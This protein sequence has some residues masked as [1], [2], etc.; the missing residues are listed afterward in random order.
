MALT[1]RREYMHVFECR[2]YGWKV[3][4]DLVHHRTRML[5]VFETKPR[6]A[7]GVSQLGHAGPVVVKAPT[8]IHHTRFDSIP[9]VRTFDQCL[10]PVNLEFYSIAGGCF[11]PLEVRMFRVLRSVTLLEVLLRPGDLNRLVGR[12]A[13][14]GRAESNEDETRGQ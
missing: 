7:D 2:L 11:Q 3:L 1:P 14:R 8:R 10:S 5:G 12:K 9:D 13:L 4:I 6:Q